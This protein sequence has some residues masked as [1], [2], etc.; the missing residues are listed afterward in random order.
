MTIVQPA[1]DAEPAPRGGLFSGAPALF[2]FALAAPWVAGGAMAL[3]LLQGVSGLVSIPLVRWREVPAGAWLFALLLIA[4]VGWAD[5]SS[6]WSAAPSA[7]EQAAKLI[8][9]VLLGLLFVAAAGANAEARRRVRAIGAACLA[10]LAVMLLIEAFAGMPIN[11]AGQPNET[12][13]TTLARN[14]ARGASFLVVCV[15]G[16]IAALAGGGSGERMAWRGL[17]LLTGIASLQ[18]DANANAAAFGFATIAYIA[19]YVLP[20]FT[21]IALSVGLAGWLL[22]APFAL[23]HLLALPQM[24]SLPPSWAIRAEIWRFVCARIAENPLMGSGLDASRLHPEHV[25]MAGQSLPQ[26]PLHPHNSSLQIWFET[27]AIGAGLLAAAILAGGFALS[28]ACAKRPQLAAGACGAIAAMGLIANVSYGAWQ[29]WWI[30]TLFAS[31][32]LVAAARR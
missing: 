8:A 12:V 28:N 15:W 31:A 20:R 3:P 22:A 24:Q 30:A 17:F 23:P 11:L 6:Q 7:I 16:V 13:M 9:A 5:A 2:F 1:A 19:G 18:F 10:V 27:G 4:F 21:V 25:P 14:P 32:A 26:I 29:E